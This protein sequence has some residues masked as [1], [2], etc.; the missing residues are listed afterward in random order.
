MSDI[1]N[2]REIENLQAE[3]ERLRTVLE[4]IQQTRV[5]QGKAIIDASNEIERLRAALEEIR[6]AGP[7]TLDDQ[8]WRI[9]LV[10]LGG[11]K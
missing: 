9:A 2:Q 6:D 3:N 1:H 5:L 10:A 8:R 11:D 7:M 4:N